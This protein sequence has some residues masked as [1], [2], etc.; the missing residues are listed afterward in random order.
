MTI[1]T[2]S[3]TDKIILTDNGYSVPWLGG[4][5]NIY[6]YPAGAIITLQLFELLLITTPSQTILAAPTTGD[7]LDEYIYPDMIN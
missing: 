7:V 2:K 1:Y 4:A 3:F 5:I 6:V